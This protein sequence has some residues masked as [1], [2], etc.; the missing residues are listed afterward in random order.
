MSTSGLKRHSTR[1]AFMEA[2]VRI[3]KLNTS[4]DR[5]MTLIL[6]FMVEK[7]KT[8]RFPSRLIKRIIPHQIQVRE[9]LINAS[10]WIDSIYR[11]C[12]LQRVMLVPFVFRR[13]R[14]RKETVRSVWIKSMFKIQVRS[15]IT[16]FHCPWDW[17]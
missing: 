11:F 4:D 3:S 12:I 15:F 10:L 1:S 6:L 14:L 2:N 13:G 17:P 8:P 9:F 5:V 7:F 16:T